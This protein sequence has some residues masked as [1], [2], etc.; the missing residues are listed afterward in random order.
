MLIVAMQFLATFTCAIFSGAAIYINLV[1][2][3]ARLSC[4]TKI[5]IAEWAPSYK[6]AT[7]MQASLAAVGFVSALIAWFGN[8][9][10]WWLIG[11]IIFGLVVPYTLIV[12][13]PTNKRLLSPNLD[14]SSEEANY[15]L[16]K[17]NNLHFIRSVFSTFALIIFLLQLVN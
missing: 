1:E 2:H 11:G 15:L 17:W 16:K 14:K 6:K 3:P 5:A 10:I 9:N 13:M 7:I 8:T 4:G 12:I